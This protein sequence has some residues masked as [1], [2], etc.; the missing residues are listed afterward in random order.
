MALDDVKRN[1]F[2]RVR[3]DTED[4][5]D[6]VTLSVRLSVPQDATAEEVIGEYLRWLEDDEYEAVRETKVKWATSGEN[7]PLG[8]DY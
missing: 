7:L 6:T 5:G 3:R 8:T 1:I 2:E 4:A